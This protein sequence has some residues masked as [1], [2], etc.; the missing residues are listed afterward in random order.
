MAMPV[1]VPAGVAVPSLVVRVVPG[2][3]VA[4]SGPVRVVRPSTLAVPAGPVRAGRPA[5]RLAGGIRRSGAARV[6]DPD[7]PV[8]VRPVAGSV[9]PGPGRPGRA[10][11]G[12]ARAGRPDRP[13]G[14]RR[15][16]L[17]E[18]REDGDRLL[19]GRT[20]L[21][22]HDHAA[23][24]GRRPGSGPAARGR[25]GGGL[26]GPARRDRPATPLR[27]LDLDHVRA[28]QV[29]VGGRLEPVRQR[30]AERLGQQLAGRHHGRQRGRRQRRHP[31]GDDQRCVA[32]RRHARR[33]PET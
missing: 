1:V 30:A 2:P 11:P 17:L 12:R 21:H 9:P 25:S 33:S 5:T 22:G 23:A 31:E 16:R 6:G 29:G 3:A 13:R 32:A 19:A 8:P 26:P 24:A 7:A 10:V 27:R 28:A 4:A 20:L 15:R 18:D 14:R